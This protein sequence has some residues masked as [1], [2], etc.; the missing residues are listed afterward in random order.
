MFNIW[1]LIAVVFS[2]FIGY[3]LNKYANQQTEKKI[4]Q[5]IKDEIASL[6]SKRQVSRLSQEEEIRIHGL[7]ETINILTTKNERL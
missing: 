5:A 3:R 7:N 2:L 4:I 1:T 6:Q